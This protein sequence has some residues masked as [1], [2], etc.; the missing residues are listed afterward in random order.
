MTS[1]FVCV[2]S[3]AYSPCFCVFS[4]D[5]RCHLTSTFF[6]RK[7]DLLKTYQKDDS[8]R[9]I[10]RCTWCSGQPLP[11]LH[12][13][14]LTNP[15]NIFQ[16]IYKAIWLNGKTSTRSSNRNAMELVGY[17]CFAPKLRLHS[18]WQSPILYDPVL[19]SLLNFKSVIIPF[20]F[21]NGVLIYPF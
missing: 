17:W 3:A 8:G 9:Q 10:F 21:V 2:L 16:L 1:T 7:E 13:R 18:L 5:I 19:Y 12:S 20:P 15:T 14:W 6:R 4:P 11:F